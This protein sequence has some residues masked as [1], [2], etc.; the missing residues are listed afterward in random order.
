MEPEA[1]LAPWLATGS[2]LTICQLQQS[3]PVLF[4][5]QL[6]QQLPLS[7]VL[8]IDS[9]GCYLPFHLETIDSKEVFTLAFLYICHGGKLI[10]HL[11][12]CRDPQT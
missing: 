1:A 2:Q 12:F 4:Q 9:R 3:I 10:S 11:A 6:C 5:Q 8:V 7:P